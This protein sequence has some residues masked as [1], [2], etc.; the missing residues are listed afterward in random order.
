MWTSRNRPMTARQSNL[1]ARHTRAGRYTVFCHIAYSKPIVLL[2][3]MRMALDSGV[4]RRRR[5][6]LHWKYAISVVTLDE[7]LSFDGQPLVIKIDVEGYEL[8]VLDG[9]KNLLVRN[10]GYAQIE[11]F[12]EHRAGSV[13]KKMAE[14]GWQL[15]D[16]IVDDLVFRRSAN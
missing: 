6:P 3:G 13:I 8:E 10:Y 2:K 9:A 15:S 16:H 1:T 7:T 11:S 5:P 4:L 14:C 12:E